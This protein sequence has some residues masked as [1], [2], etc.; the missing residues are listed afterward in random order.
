MNVLEIEVKEVGFDRYEVCITEQ[1]CDVLTRG[2]FVD[3]EIGVLSSS[4]PAYVFNN[5]YGILFIRGNKLEEDNKKF[6]VNTVDLQNIHRKVDA[7]NA[8]Y[9]TVEKIE[10]LKVV[11]TPEM[12]DVTLT[13]EPEEKAEV[14]NGK[15]TKKRTK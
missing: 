13:I 9:A 11:E 7:V 1:N 2:K 14:K 3:K 4:T 10:V 15:K 12:I 8:K 5:E 6:Y